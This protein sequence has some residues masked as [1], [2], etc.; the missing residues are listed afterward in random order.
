[1]IRKFAALLVI[2]LILAACSGKD[3]PFHR[4]QNPTPLHDEQVLPADTAP[5]AAPVVQQIPV[6]AYLTALRRAYELDRAAAP[7]AQQSPALAAYLDSGL[8]LSDAYCL[9]WFRRL[10]DAQRGISFAQNNFNVVRQL[11][12][13]LIGVAR[14][15]SDV[16]TVYGATNTAI[17]GINANINETL[18]L[19]PD[20][21][22]IKQRV[23]EAMADRA[24]QLRGASRPAGFVD[25]YVELERYA[26]MC[27]FAA[28][29]QYVN[30][31]ISAPDARATADP[32]TGGIILASAATRY[33]AQHADQVREL[34]AAVDALDDR[35][36]IALA[37]APPVPAIPGFGA[38]L[39][40]NSG[41]GARAYL[42]RLLT[43]TSGDA[44]GLAKW[45]AALAR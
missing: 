41:D 20:T 45:R 1:M 27:S 14:L 11:G 18:F 9:R 34:Q 44:A 30:Q 16:T 24:T 40:R 35:R 12:T 2:P 37:A 7:A 29:R 32:E 23:L 10:D 21:A 39:D 26:D 15:N 36:A 19:A 43:L 8:A 42:K 13:A 33:Q 28:A 6:N 17:E 31:T 5:P 25:T 3:D 4:L 22:L 38:N